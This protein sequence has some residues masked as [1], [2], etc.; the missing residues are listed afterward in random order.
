VELCTLQARGMALDAALK[1]AQIWSAGTSTCH[2][3]TQRSYAL[4][5][6]TQ[7]HTLPELAAHG[8]T[9][10]GTHG[11]TLKAHGVKVQHGKL[12]GLHHFS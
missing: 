4:L 3:Y 12:N 7:L 10:R 5:T 8:A 1:R 6:G 2:P 9:H 11:C